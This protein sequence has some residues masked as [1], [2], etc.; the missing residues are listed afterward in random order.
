MSQDIPSIEGIKAIVVEMRSFA[1]Y[2]AERATWSRRRIRRE[3]ARS[4]RQMSA[5]YR[6]SLGDF[7]EWW[8]MNASRQ[9]ETRATPLWTSK[10]ARR[11]RE[12]TQRKRVGWIPGVRWTIYCDL[13]LVEQQLTEITE[14]F[15]RGVRVPT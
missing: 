1:R 9:P 7:R 12:R 4:D 8:E 10:H 15:A 6:R 13:S 5:G 11:R 3:Y 14:A 2:V